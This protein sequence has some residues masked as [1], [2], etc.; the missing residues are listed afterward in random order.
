[1]GECL[2]TQVAASAGGAGVA[3]GE[4]HLPCLLGGGQEPWGV[5][6]TRARGAGAAGGR[7]PAHGEGAG[8][9]K[10]LLPASAAGVGLR[11]ALPP[12][13]EAVLVHRRCH[14]RS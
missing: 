4:L 9:R 13:E 6:V 11:G 3:S 7:G 12:A 10:A 1:M 5:G 14:S 2:G 8:V